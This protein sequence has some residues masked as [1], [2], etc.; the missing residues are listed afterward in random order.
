M[1][2]RKLVVRGA[3]EHNLKNVD[4]ALPRDSLVVLTGLSGSGKSSLAFDTIYAEG[5]RRYVE[6]LSAYAR[7]FL[8]MMQKP[9]VDQ[10]DGLSPAISIEQK[11]TSRN[12]RSTV[13]TVTEIYDYMRL[14]WARIGVP[15]SPVTGLPIES[16]TVSQM[17]D[18]LL[19]LRAKTRL[20]LLAPIV[21]GRKG[22]YRR[23]LAELQKKGFQRVKID[24]TFYEIDAAPALDKKFKHDIDVVVDR[25]STRPDIA[26]RLADSIETALRLADGI[27]IAEFA[28]EMDGDEPRRIVFSERF[29]CPV[30]GFTIAEIEP[31]LFSFNAPTGACPECDGLGTTLRFEPDLVVPDDTLSL[32]E[33]AILPWAKTGNTSPYYTQTLMA[34][35]KHYR[36]DMTTPW[37]DLSDKVKKAILYGSGRDKIEFVY[38]DGLRSY[39][40]KKAFEGVITNIERRWGE[41]DSQWVRDEL[42]RFQSDAPCEA[43]GGYRLRPEALAVKVGGEHISAVAELSIR[44]AAPWFLALPETLSDKE[45]EIARAILKEI[46]ERLR[47]LIDVGLD[48]LQLSRGSRTLSGGES[49]RIRLASQIGSGLT[50]VLYVLDEPSIGLHQRDNARL[51]ETLKRLRD[52]GNT[53]IVVEHDEDAVLAADYVVDVGPGAGVHGGQVVAEGTPQE[54]MANPNSLTGQY[55]SGALEIAVPKKRR[56]RKKGR[57]INVVGAS[58]NN[59]RHV[60]AEIP[61]GLFTAVTGVSGSG[62][63]TLVIETLYRAVSRKLNK[64]RE[65]PAPHEAITGL[66]YLDKIIDIDQSPIGRTPR[67]N[68]AT[69]TGAF[70]P[71]REWFAGLPEAKARGYGPGRF[72]F[73][74]KGGRCEACQGDGVIKIEMHFLP[75]VYVT[76]DVCKG[77]RYNRETLEI[78]FKGK[79]ISDVLEMTV[80]EGCEFFKAVP[81][82]RDKLVTLQ[83]VGLDYIKIGQQATT[84]SGGEAQRIKLAKEL[85]KRATGRTLYILDEP[86]TGLHFH[87]VAKLLDVLQR[88]VS[89]G[90]TVVVIE[91][92]LEVIKTADWVIDLGPEGGD[93]GGEIIASG[94]P[95][96][97]AKA[98]RS[99]TGQ[100]LTDVLGRRAPARNAAA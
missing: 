44:D 7:Q 70:T 85:S 14:L 11:T 2:E 25:I 91:H 5:Q 89:Q 30:S 15:H 41:T 59:L 51:I 29:A 20:Y 35:A 86:T 37:R 79:S 90:N 98:S 52:L 27:A 71:I 83:E 60:D 63:S 6:S 3:R 68:P 64:S 38:D 10:I 23:E 19:A 72:S 31:R 22:E 43:C 54:I 12:P 24:G 99:Y 18:K 92:N 100:F 4:I 33:G 88:L 9:D 49:Q 47:F 75:D 94:K 66:E 67:S 56:T 39:K 58:G 74:V 42:S 36:A 45:F 55:L 16:Q 95:E 81:A 82:V 32:S 93:G 26:T 69:Y 50:G 21:R 53:V 77:K 62:K 96:A 84:L 61:L 73:N 65:Q 46:Q 87:D 8:E 28:D 97:V 1:Q 48:Y 80:E 17:V 40:T 34:V 76:C 78:E 13:G 57:V